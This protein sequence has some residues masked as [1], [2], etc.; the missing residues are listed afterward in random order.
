MVS[1]RSPQQTVSNAAYLL[2]YRRRSDQPLGGP[3]FQKIIEE[4]YR[5][6]D[7]PASSR[8]SSPAGDD[9]R[10]DT[11]SRGGSSSASQGV[12]AGR[13]EPTDLASGVA[14]ITQDEEELPAYSKLYPGTGV[15]AL[16]M[17][18]TDNMDVDEGIDTSSLD[19]V[20]GPF[21]ENPGWGFDNQPVINP[22]LTA[23]QASPGS[24]DEEIMDGVSDKAADGS[25]GNL[26]DRS[27]RMADFADDDDDDGTLGDSF[28]NTMDPHSLSDSPFA[29]MAL[30]SDSDGLHV[31]APAI[32][33]DEDVEDEDGPVAEVHVEQEEGL[34][35]SD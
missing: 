27:D 32:R 14:G 29:D 15:P 3:S 1:K 5:Q 2:F 7:S 21:S 11:S 16:T 25:S 24:S 28:S 20:V 9:Q 10:L 33:D 19:Q 12:G 4:A 8:T 23:P 13:Q 34:S 18:G 31:Q 6:R 35:K 22:I 26:S 30:G 17:T